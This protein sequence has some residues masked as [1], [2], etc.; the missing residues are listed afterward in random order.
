MRQ[1]PD[2][3]E[4]RAEALLRRI[5]V[6]VPALTL[7][8]VAGLYAGI[9][10]CQR[11]FEGGAGAIVVLS[12]LLVH[13]FVIVLV[14]DGSHR[15]ITRTRA[16]CVAMNLGSGLV[17]L[18]FYAEL[19]RRYHLIHHAH[20]NEAVDPL[21]PPFKKRLYAEHRRL[22][23]LAELLPFLFTILLL[24]LGARR[25][26]ARR[27][28]GPPVRAGYLALSL[29]T[30]IATAWWVRPPLAFV[31]LS[32]LCANAWG[33]VRH[34]CEHMGFDRAR[35]GNTFRFPLGMG[36]G[37]HDAHHRHPGFSWISMAAGLALRP[38]DTG[39]LRTVWAMLRHPEYMPYAASRP[40]AGQP[41]A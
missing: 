4:Q 15:A 6:V 35:E 36:V 13:A 17:L 25:E 24:V 32:L 9:G 23:M 14:H 20:T 29:C 2:T 39:P 34:W 41:P 8:A 22:Y 37:N 33:A 40:G 31:L 10:A 3:V 27:A 18:P 7:V 19:F 26:T 16:D 1:T 30:A 12:G 11:L 5:P 21:W 38:K 28:Q